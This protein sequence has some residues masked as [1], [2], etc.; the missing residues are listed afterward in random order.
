MIKKIIKLIAMGICYGC[1]FSC[2][3]S[4]VGYSIL[5]NEWFVSSPKGYCIQ[6]VA[7]MIVGIG[8]TLPTLIYSQEKLSKV[9]QCLIHIGIGVV[10][11]IPIAF[12]MEWMPMDNLALMLGSVMFA[13]IVSLFVWCG[14]YLYYKKEA[15]KI[16]KE[17]K[18]M[19]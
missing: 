13:V 2:L 7:A 3:I 15:Q 9:Q 17:L 12:Y 19:K 6:I 5:G 1:T 14:F 4:M 11:Y 10:V 18:E 8:W 16:N